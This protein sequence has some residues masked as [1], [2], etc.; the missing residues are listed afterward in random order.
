N[1]NPSIHQMYHHPSHPNPTL[2]STLTS[3]SHH[4]PSP[5]EPV[6]PSLNLDPPL[7]IRTQRISLTLPGFSS[8]LSATSSESLHPPLSHS[9]HS[10]SPLPHSN[11][12]NELSILQHSSDPSLQLNPDSTHIEQGSYHHRSEDED[13]HIDLHPSLIY[14]QDHIQPSLYHEM[15][16]N[17]QPEDLTLH[18]NDTS[19]ENPDTPSRLDHLADSVHSH[20]SPSSDEL[21]VT[22]DQSL[23]NPNSPLSEAPSR[24]LI[25]DFDDHATRVRLTSRLTQLRS[26][27]E[28]SI[29][30]EHNSPQ[31]EEDPSMIHQGFHQNRRKRSRTAPLVFQDLPL[32]D[33][34]SSPCS[35]FTTIPTTADL[36]E[37][38]ARNTN[39]YRALPAFY[40]QDPEILTPEI[41]ISID[42]DPMSRRQIIL[43]HSTHGP[44]RWHDATQKAIYEAS[45][46]G[47]VGEEIGQISFDYL[48][49]PPRDKPRDRTS[50]ET[51]EQA[52]D[53]E[54]SSTSRV[55]DNHHLRSF[56]LTS[57]EWGPPTSYTSFR[58][59]LDLRPTSFSWGRRAMAHDLP[60]PPS[61]ALL[62]PMGSTY[63]QHFLTPNPNGRP[64]RLSSF[65]R[66]PPITNNSSSTSS[67][68]SRI[69]RREEMLPPSFTRPP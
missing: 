35:T 45:K 63:L 61:S 51:S 5:T 43:D 13:E 42:T 28:R 20:L 54:E 49:I 9:N 31:S 68:S 65:A 36:A 30:P 60:L 1:L 56:Y 40:S 17:T 18:F 67:S 6:H 4:H 66:L 7:P 62:D 39:P 25:S 58:E 41:T 47:L 24:S 27:H 2:I 59:S 19:T 8:I 32:T 46:D 52:E 29:S 3:S 16:S 15:S 50:T 12:T 14:V 11:Q 48:S 55:T 44:I 38:A 37:E 34:S 22:L 57:G 23:V 10:S 21:H 33:P 26:P 69:M 53:S 64:T